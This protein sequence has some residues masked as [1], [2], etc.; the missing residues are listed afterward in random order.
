MAN[1]TK[2]AEDSVISGTA[3]VNASDGRVTKLIEAATAD[4]ATPEEMAALFAESGVQVSRGE[5][6]TGDYVVI[7][8]ESEKTAWCNSHIGQSLFVVMWNF[9][10]GQNEREFAAMHI[11]AHDGKF[12]VNDGAQG[13]MY[14]QLRQITDTRERS[15]PKSIDNRTAF[16]GL[17]V[18]EGLR[19]NKPFDWDTR[20]GKAI[21]KGEEVPSEFRRTSRQTWSFAL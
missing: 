8:G 3:L 10:D 16:A 4:V 13:G 19:A 11:V 6:I 15:N 18:S 5:E 9:Y 7:R 17:M 12:I 20:T 21:K 2:P 14:G 1:A